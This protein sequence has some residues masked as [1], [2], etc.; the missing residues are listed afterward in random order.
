MLTLIIFGLQNVNKQK[1]FC[2]A[3]LAFLRHAY[4]CFYHDFA[5]VD[6][7]GSAFYWQLTFSRA[8]K[9]FRNAVL[10]YGMQHR[11]LFNTRHFTNLVDTA[12][13]EACERFASVIDIGEGGDFALQPVLV[14]AVVD[15]EQHGANDRF[16]NGHTHQPFRRRP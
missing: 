4:E 15:A 5:N 16:A 2:T 6:L 8:L 12:P 1:M 14:D 11:I 7:Q 3:A 9:S 13:Q 10:R